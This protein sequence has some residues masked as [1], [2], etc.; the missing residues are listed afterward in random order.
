MSTAIVLSVGALYDPSR[1]PSKPITA[2]SS[3]TPMPCSRNARNAPKAIASVMQ[4]SPSNGKSPSSMR[5]ETARYASSVSQSNS[6]I[7]SALVSVRSYRSNARWQ[8][9]RRR[10][11]TCIDRRAWSA[12]MKSAPTSPTRSHPISNRCV[13]AASAPFSHGVNT[14]SNGPWYDWSSSSTTGLPLLSSM[15]SASLRPPALRIT[16]SQNR[17]ATFSRMLFSWPT[18]PVEICCATAWMPRSSA[19][20]DTLA[21]SCA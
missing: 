3:G 7:V 10:S 12:G 19:A 11:P 4:N 20:F 9:I 2:T 8:P 17:L 21:S 13:T 18:L 6:W 1:T 15:I 14:E 16:P 5:R